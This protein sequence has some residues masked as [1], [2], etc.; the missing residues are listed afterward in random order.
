MP[1]IIEMPNNDLIACDMAHVGE[2]PIAKYQIPTA[3]GGLFLCDKCFEEV[4]LEMNK[5]CAPWRLL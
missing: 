1:E 3:A 4:R 2:L 5:I